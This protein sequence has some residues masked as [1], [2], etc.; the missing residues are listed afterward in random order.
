MSTTHS[1]L[2]KCLGQVISSR[3]KRLHMSQEELAQESG[4]NRAFISNIEQGGRKPS[5]G[6]IANLSRGLRIRYSRLI[7]NCEECM[8][9]SA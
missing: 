8:A 9:K 1:H 3:R 5:F 6:A 4:I 2:Y 7:A